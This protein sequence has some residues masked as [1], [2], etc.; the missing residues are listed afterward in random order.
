M[1]IERIYL[2][3]FDIDRYGNPLLPFDI[4]SYKFHSLI[5]YYS[6]MLLINSIFSKTII[7][8]PAAPLKIESLAA[9]LREKFFPCILHDEYMNTEKPIISIGI[10]SEDKDFESYVSTRFEFLK[11]SP[12]NPERIAY[13]KN[14]YKNSANWLNSLIIRPTVLKSSV[15]ETYKKFAKEFISNKKQNSIKDYGLEFLEKNDQFQTFNFLIGYE[16][17]FGNNYSLFNQLRKKYISA[18]A[19]AYIAT[20]PNDTIFLRPDNLLKFASVIGL[21]DAIGRWENINSSMV[22]SIRKMST[23]KPLI[24]EY[25]NNYLQSD[26]DYFF[27]L[28]NA[29]FKNENNILDKIIS[30]QNIFPKLKY[31]NIEKFSKQDTTNIKYSHRKIVEMITAFKSEISEKLRF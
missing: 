1:N 31:I 5:D 10:T 7:L 6:T 15:S 3:Y 20:N 19:H 12:N 27:T 28:S 26:I 29:E 17:K 25:S 21:K 30:F 11:N 22:F 23:I 16:N 9:C 24:D 2:G 14:N 13:E 18:H 8:Q 4:S